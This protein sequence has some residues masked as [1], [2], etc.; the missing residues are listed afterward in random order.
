M[1]VG[2]MSRQWVGRVDVELVVGRVDVEVVG[3]GRMSR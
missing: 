3:V 1:G 2:R